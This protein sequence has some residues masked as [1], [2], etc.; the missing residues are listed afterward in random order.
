[1]SG[2]SSHY[3]AAKLTGLTGAALEAVIRG[4]MRPD[5]L[6]GESR[7]EEP[8]RRGEE[9]FRGSRWAEAQARPL[10]DAS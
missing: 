4:K 6:F 3:V 2:H 1:M 9:S 8:A 10:R 5:A 7:A